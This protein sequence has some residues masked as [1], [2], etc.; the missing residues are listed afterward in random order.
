MDRRAF[1]SR[2]AAA[3]S[4]VLV[5][6]AGLAACSS[7]PSSTG[8]GSGGGSGTPGVNKGTP[9]TGGSLTI[10]TTA[11]IDGFFPPNNH[12]DN[13]GFLYANAV[14]DP[15]TAVAADGTIKPYL[16]QSVTPNSTYTVWTLTLRPGITFHDGSAL[17]ATVVKNN[18]DALKASTL[19]GIALQQVKSA[20]VTGPLTLVYTCT[21]PLVDFPAGL[22]TQVG[23]VVGQAMLD[24]VKASSTA[25][26]KPIGTGP[27]V[28]GN[29][30]PNQQFSATR[31]PN[32]WRSG[33]P[34][35][36]SITF[37]PIPD[38]TQREST[39]KTGG[40]DLIVSADPNTVNHFVGQSAFQ[41]VDTLNYTVG[42][43][44]MD[45][46]MLNCATAPTNDLRIRQALAK[47]T[48]QVQVNK[49]FGGG[50]A[51]LSNGLF[52]KGSKYYSTTAYPTFDL[53]GA[54]ALVAA[55]KAQHGTAAL[56]LT[57]TTDPRV[58]KATQ[59]L[60]QMWNL[61]GFDITI[62]A[63]EQAALITDAITGTYQALTFEQFA[64]PDPDL[65]Y[66]WWST[67]TVAPPGQIS[68]NF[69]RNSDPL[70]EQALQIGRTNPDPAT[71]IKAYQTVNERICL[72]L[73]YIW[74]GQTVW[75]EV[76]DTRVQNFAN[77][78]LPDGAPGYP[79]QN[80]FF[81]PTQIWMAG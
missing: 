79:F 8:G 33:L 54:K 50:L 14:Y 64:V 34:Y 57:G 69:A 49:I 56:T 81:F 70:I 28:Y 55:Y 35:L 77:P 6:A 17:T 25:S 32:Y 45:F 3:G 20:T 80:G 11:E 60:Q 36:N 1:L 46:I 23:Y 51:K 67:T 65:N 5:G 62:K 66:T 13:N 59:V 75:S 76:G 10:G 68:L 29:W 78:V 71:R 31:N 4:L 42:E 73:P 41:V 7:S 22:A 18:F 37:K 48:D 9:K 53:P 16:A 43:P 30:Q 38:T 15:L 2:G 74:L 19:T 63:I 21:Q 58:S 39:L 72:D 61:A 27:F 40:V 26:P 44:D 24:A 52:P 47:A 12:W